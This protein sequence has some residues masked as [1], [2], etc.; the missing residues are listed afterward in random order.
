MD[1]DN[2]KPKVGEPGGGFVASSI[3]VRRRDLKVEPE[4]DVPGIANVSLKGEWQFAMGRRGALLITHRP[5]QTHLPPGEVLEHLYQVPDLQNKY[6]VTS[7]F[8]CPAY[9][10]YLSDKSATGGSEIRLDWWTQTQASFPP[11]SMQQ[12]WRVFIH[13]PFKRLEVQGVSLRT[14]VP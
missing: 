3:G 5:R 4:L 2:H 10:I 14:T 12:E 8:S 13:P 1:L 9:S 11:Q 6:I 7:V